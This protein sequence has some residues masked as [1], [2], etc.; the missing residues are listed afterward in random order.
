MQ[1]FSLLIFLFSFSIVNAQDTLRFSEAISYALEHQLDI[2]IA[3]I[4]SENAQKQASIGN[5]GMLPQLGV[6]ATYGVSSLNLRQELQN[7]TVIER[8]NA[9]S[10]ITQA[11]AA[12]NWVL[13]DGTR[14]FS[15]YNRLRI[16]SS[17]AIQDQ[18]LVLENIIE[19]LAIQYYEA[20]RLGLQL[21]NANLILSASKAR[22]DYVN[23]RYTLGAANRQE[24]LQAMVDYNSQTVLFRNLQRDFKVALTKVNELMGRDVMQ[25]WTPENTVP[26]IAAADTLKWNSGEVN[27]NLLLVRRKLEVNSAGY[28]HK[29]ARGSLFPQLSLEATY[30]FNR[31]VNEAG[32]NLL[33]RNYGPYIGLNASWSL[34]NGNQQNLNRQRLMY[35]YQIAK[36]NAQRQEQRAKSEMQVALLFYRNAAETVELA[37]ANQELARENLTIAEERFRLGRSSI[38]EAREA[39][40]SFA[41]AVTEYS[42]ALVTLRLA[43]LECLRVSGELIQLAE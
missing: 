34:Y 7:G 25:N 5:A 43:E 19:Q 29:E 11:G 21:Q 42:D 8:D 9:G 27:A 16:N 41:L 3:Q 35:Q 10:Q 38:L 24:Y 1:K 22:L 40:S 12:F 23:Q 36:L 39:L 30:N 6:S 4:N 32:F 37:K 20:S 18:K 26:T 17:I 14:M 28:E 13:F 31:Q 33:N 15:A 2:Q